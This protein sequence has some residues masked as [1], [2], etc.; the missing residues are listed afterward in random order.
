[1]ITLTEHNA[2]H[3]TCLAICGIGHFAVDF[4]CAFTILAVHAHGAVADHW[5][6]AV[7]VAYNLLAFGSQALVGSLLDRRMAFAEGVG[8]GLTL[9]ALGV[10]L[11]VSRPFAALALLGCGNAIFHVSAGAVVY[12][13]QPGRAGGPGVFVAPGGLGLIAGIVLGREGAF[14]PLWVVPVLC[15]LA[16][17]S[18][19]LLYSHKYSLMAASFD[20]TLRQ[21]REDRVTVLPFPTAVLALLLLVVALRSFTGFALPAPWKGGNGLWMLAAAAFAGKASGG[22]LADRFGWQPV[23][24]SL[25]IAAALLGLFHNISLPAACGALFCLQATTGVTLTGVQT[26]FPGRPAFAFGLPCLALLAGAFPFY[27]P[28]PMGFIPPVL[29]LGLGLVAALSARVA[30]TATS[31]GELTCTG[32]APAMLH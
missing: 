5:Y 1:M 10:A 28:E 6:F 29:L 16:V 17:C 2:T 14:S 21:E 8:L 30:L 22:F 25:L 15:I 23:C 31:K 11:A 9:T 24:T 7:V 27:L 20:R 32:D 19:R 18:Y 12:K 4:G 13:A 26:I 3:P